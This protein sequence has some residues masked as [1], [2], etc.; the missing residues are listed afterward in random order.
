MERFIMKKW[1][2]RRKQFSTL[3]LATALIGNRMDLKCYTK[4]VT[5]V[6]NKI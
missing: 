4:V 2:K 6:A 3:L 1:K 5:G